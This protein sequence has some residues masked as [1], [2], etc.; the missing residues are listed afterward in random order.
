MR[1]GF[2]ADVDARVLDDIERQAVLKRF[3]TGQ[4]VFSQGDVG[5]ALYIVQSGRFEA[6]VGTADG[7][8][9]VARI[10]GPG[11][12]FGEITLLDS[13]LGRTATIKALEASSVL[14]ISSEQFDELRRRDPV[15]DRAIIRSLTELIVKLTGESVDNAFLSAERRLAKRLLTLA[16]VYSPIP[17]TSSSNVEIPVTQEHLALATGSTRPTV[18]RL[19]GEL[20]TKGVIERSRNA[21]T[22]CNVD[23]LQALAW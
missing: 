13:R 6:E 17:L 15:V 14:V 19:L 10:H 20:Q 3:R 21:V 11:S 5:K 7:N 18:N 12:Q 23:L 22:V 1:W 9:M 2:L 16:E 4:V 8:I